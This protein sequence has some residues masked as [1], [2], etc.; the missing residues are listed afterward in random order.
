MIVTDSTIRGS[1]DV[2]VPLYYDRDVISIL[3]E[4][5]MS[6]LED[7][8]ADV[9]LIL[10]DDGSTDGT[11]KKALEIVESDSRVSLIQLTKNF[12]QHRAINAGLRVSSAD[13]VAI[14]DSDLQDS[15]EDIPA[16]IE[17]MESEDN[18]MSIALR[19]SRKDS[20]MK[21]FSSWS[22][23][24]VSNRLVPFK[25]DPRLGSFR[26]LTRNLVDQLTAVEET[27]GTPFSLLYYMGVPFSTLSLDREG[28]IAG[29]SG[30]TIKKSIKLASD[31]IMT[32]SVRPMRL[33]TYL[34]LLAGLMSLI[35]GGYV[36]VNFILQDKVVP[37]W[38][39]IVFLTTFFG[40]LNLIF[41][42][43]IGEYIG[44]IYLESR[45]VPQFMVHSY[46]GRLGDS[47]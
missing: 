1:I 27:T 41:L 47:E 14:M 19:K 22:F 5:V 18:H 46:H 12:G 17:K 36:L 25:I 6:A 8:F 44:R 24:I 42:G 20:L 11:S 10:I 2:V 40:G 15:P 43:L 33:A 34:G 29:T 31:R 39:S 35:T 28:R 4:R 13:Y 26:V 16:L 45:G 3:H 38:T 37:G 21:R 9:H 32:Y 7:C 30:Y 23:T